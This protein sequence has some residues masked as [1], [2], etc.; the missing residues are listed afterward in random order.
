MAFSA[1]GKRPVNIYRNCFDVTEGLWA[2]STAYVLWMLENHAEWAPVPLERRLPMRLRGPDIFKATVPSLVYAPIHFLCTSYNLL[3]AFCVLFPLTEQGFTWNSRIKT[4]GRNPRKQKLRL[5]FEVFKMP[6]SIAIC[7][8]AGSQVKPLLC[9]RVFE[10]GDSRC[11]LR[12]GCE[13]AVQGR[14][15][16]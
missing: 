1:R 16:R 11:F 15:S 2:L 8:T 5:G 3:C 7:V 4:N 13:K 6:P 14:S 10:E 9:Y 12:A